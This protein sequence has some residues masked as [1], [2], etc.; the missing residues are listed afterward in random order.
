MGASGGAKLLDVVGQAIANDPAAYKA[1]AP[2]SQVADK[3]GTQV[4]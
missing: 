3:P 2:P 1:L 4:H